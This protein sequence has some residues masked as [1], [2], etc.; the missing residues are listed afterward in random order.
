VDTVFIG[1]STWWWNRRDNPFCVTAEGKCIKVL[2]R[3]ELHDEFL[4]DLTDEIR[5]LR[6]HGKRVIVCLPFPFYSQR[7]PALEMSNAI[8]ARFGS[9]ETPRETDSVQL[10]D[11]IKAIALKADAE[12]FDPRET[13]CSGVTC[14]TDRGGVSIYSDSNHLATSQVN[15][16]ENSLRTVLQQ[17]LSSNALRSQGPTLRK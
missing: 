17:N 16:L 4:A 2:S 10:H 12:L 9:F 14:I 3:E 5:L 6:N 13:L 15:I 11:E 1:S 8:F 7:L